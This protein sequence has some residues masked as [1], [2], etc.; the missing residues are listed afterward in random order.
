M[1]QAQQQMTILGQ[2]EALWN[3][4]MAD[5]PIPDA[6]GLAT[7]LA[8][9]RPASARANML[10][11]M[12]EVADLMDSLPQP[13]APPKPPTTPIQK[14]TEADAETVL[15]MIEEAYNKVPMGRFATALLAGLLAD[16]PRTV[17]RWA[18]DQTDPAKLNLHQLA[19]RLTAEDQ[20]MQAQYERALAKMTD[21]AVQPQRT[22]T[23]PM[24][25]ISAANHA[26]VS[27][28]EEVMAQLGDR[29]SQSAFE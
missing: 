12:K 7:E 25:S 19:D 10:T 27:A 1:Q 17:L 11:E 8:K 18:Q 21:Q 13:K 3:Q 4:P 5:Q 15:M 6:Q 23:D 26:Q 29:L 14:L 28:T 24:A 9:A 16:H 22:Q 20:T 2:V